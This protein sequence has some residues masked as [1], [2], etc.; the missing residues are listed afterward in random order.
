MGGTYAFVSTA[1]ANL[2]ASNDPT[3]QFLGGFAAGAV[4]GLK[5]TLADSS[6]DS[7]LTIK[8]VEHSRQS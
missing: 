7:C 4:G 2:R 8:Q 3:N 6:V 1:S 5:R